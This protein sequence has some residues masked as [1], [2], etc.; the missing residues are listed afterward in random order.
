MTAGMGTSGLLI[1]LLMI[2][3]PGGGANIFI[4]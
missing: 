4:R 3:I 2:T 1:N